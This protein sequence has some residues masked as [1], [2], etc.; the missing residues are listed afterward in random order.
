MMQIYCIAT[1]NIS[2]VGRKYSVC[3]FYMNNTLGDGD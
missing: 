2:F 1:A 3:L